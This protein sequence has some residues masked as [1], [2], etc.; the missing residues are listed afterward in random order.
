VHFRLVTRRVTF[1][2]GTEA[3]WTQAAGSKQRLSG[4]SG[5]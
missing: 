5:R 1:D 2:G 4:A 3:R